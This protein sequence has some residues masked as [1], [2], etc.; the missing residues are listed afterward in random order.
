MKPTLLYSIPL[1][2]LIVVYSPDGHAQI[3]HGEIRGQ[4]TDDQFERVPY[5]TVRILQ[6]NQLIGGAQTDDKGKYTVKPLLPGFYEM[7]VTEPG[8][9]TQPVNRVEVRAGEATYV[10]LRLR[11]N[12]LGTIEVTAPPIVYTP[13][14]VDPTMFQMESISGRDLQQMAGF[15]SGDIKSGVTSITSDVVESANGELHFRGGRSDAS[16]NYVDGVKTYGETIVPGLAIENLTVFSGGVPACYGDL[17]SGMVM[18]T[19]KSYFSGIREKNLRNAAYREQRQQDK[20]E[21]KAREEEEA[22]K[23]EIEAEKAKDK[24]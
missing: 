10:D 7:I 8:H 21:K 14:A 11:S 22:R 12:T 15:I 19:T 24:K 18:V 9:L 5:A 20:Q 1:L 2:L 6:G 17:T 4:L 3:A 16:S 13:A 23:R